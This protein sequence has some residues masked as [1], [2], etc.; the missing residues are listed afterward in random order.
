MQYYAVIGFFCLS[1]V[2]ALIY[3]VLNPTKG[4][5]NMPVIDESAMLIHNGQGHRYQQAGNEFFQDW[6]IA[7]AKK[8]FEQGLSDSN[9]INDCKSK[10][11]ESMK[12]PEKFDWREENPQCTKEEPPK[13]DQNCTDS[14]L[15]A[16]LSAAEDRICK[17]GGKGEHIYLSSQEILDCDPASECKRGTV[18]KVLMWGKR[19][20]FVPESC[21]PR[22]GKAGTCPDM[23]LEDNECR[24]NNNFYKVVDMC[25]TSEVDGI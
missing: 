17:Q 24:L 23:H 8:L 20:G 10:T 6:T 5:S 2:G 9:T 25:V 14:Y 21:Y 18:N 15:L 13:I 22:T 11:D 1:M 4:F 3:T 19:R 7:D 16:T 12:I